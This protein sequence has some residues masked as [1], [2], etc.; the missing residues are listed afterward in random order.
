LKSKM[1]T[2]GSDCPRHF[3]ASFPDLL[4]VYG[5]SV[6]E[7]FI[8]LQTKIHNIIMMC[9]EKCMSNN[10]FSHFTE[11]RPN[12]YIMA[13]AALRNIYSICIFVSDTITNILVNV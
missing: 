5:T 1:A 11:T 7:S 2:I 3:S 10:K 6:V 8:K 9:S 4:H 12:G 13:Y